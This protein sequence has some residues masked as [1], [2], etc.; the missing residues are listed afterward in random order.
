[1]GSTQASDVSGYVGADASIHL[2]KLVSV[3]NG[4]N[5]WFQGTD[6]GNTLASAI[7]TDAAHVHNGTPT[8]IAGNTQVHYGFVVTNT[9]DAG[10]QPAT[11][12][13]I[14]DATINFHYA[15][16]GS[17]A[18]GASK[19]YDFTGATSALGP[20]TNT[21]TASETVSDGFGNSATPH[22]TD[23]ATYNGLGIATPGLSKGYWA[24]HSWTGVLGKTATDIVL[25]DSNMDNSANDTY[26]LKVNIAGAQ[27]WDNSN[28]TGDGRIILGGQLIAAQMN[29]DQAHVTAAG[30]LTQGAKWLYTYG[31]QDAGNN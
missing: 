7:G 16:S 20:H 4:V 25:G 14:D 2:Q 22:D 17:L 13:T 18:T 1:G 3:D 29:A 19:F 24:N 5:W 6:D 31:G 11:G 27:Q 12:V 8:T 28:A 15:F 23:S 21:A 9:S 10:L 26:D 30:L